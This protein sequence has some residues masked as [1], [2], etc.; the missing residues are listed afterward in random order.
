[1]DKYTIAEMAYKNG[2]EAGKKEFADEL[3]SI[4]AQKKEATAKSRETYYKGNGDE[5]G[6]AFWLGRGT[7]YA[8][9]LTLI[10]ELREG[11]GEDKD[12]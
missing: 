8:E 12:V 7:T 11:I 9:V 4:I 1:M 5:E 2:H 3:A 10:L 6:F